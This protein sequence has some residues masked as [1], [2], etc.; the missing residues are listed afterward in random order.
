MITPT[1]IQRRRVKGWKA[2]EGA[3]YVGRGTKWGNPFVVRGPFSIYSM[4][5]VRPVWIVARDGVDVATLHSKEDAQKVAVERYEMLIK[6]GRGPS[7]ERIR[8]ALRG[9]T[10]M[11]WCEEGTPCHADSLL[12]IANEGSAAQ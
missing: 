7:P 2:P 12:R 9:K 11:C 5:E 1:R 10:L 6:G 4:M 8:A 3:V